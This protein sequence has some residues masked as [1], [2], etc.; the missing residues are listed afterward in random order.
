MANNSSNDLFMSILAMDAYNQGYD[1]KLIHGKTN[2]GGAEVQERPVSSTIAEWKSSGFYAASYKVGGET[3]ISYRGTNTD[4]EQT[5]GS[6]IWSGWT[7][8]A[9]YT[10]PGS[11]AG[12]AF[13]FYEDVT[14]QSTGDGRAENVTLTGHSL[15]GGLAGLIGSTTGTDAILFDHMPFTIAAGLGYVARVRTY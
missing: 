6:D 14:Q 9:G 10:G 5:T 15:G 1:T 2:I 11:Q 4:T 7:V 3:I 12:L 8:A 13:Q